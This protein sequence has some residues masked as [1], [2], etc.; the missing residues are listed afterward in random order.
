MRAAEYFPDFVDKVDDFIVV[1]DNV[2]RRPARKGGVRAEIEELGNGRRVVLGG[3]GYEL[4][5]GMA[6]R[7]CEML[8]GCRQLRASL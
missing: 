3:R 6:A 7:L 8:D 1:R 4:S 5:W 2:G